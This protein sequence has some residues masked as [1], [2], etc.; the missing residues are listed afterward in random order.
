M[1]YAW[2]DLGDGR[3]VY[4]RVDSQE[5]ARSHLPSPMIRSDSLDNV[6]N[7]VDGK[8]YD[9]KSQYERAVKDAGCEIVG[10]DAGHWNGPAK[11][12]KPEGIKQ[13]LKQALAE[14]GF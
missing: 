9:S 5:R 3:Q 11:Q 8:R 6:W 7:P 12:R 14:Q 2:I 4:R 10:N 13:D 1:T